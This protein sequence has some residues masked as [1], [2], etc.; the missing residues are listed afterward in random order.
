[1]FSSVVETIP[2]KETFSLT[3]FEILKQATSRL[4]YL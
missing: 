1:M 3:L 2:P 4:F